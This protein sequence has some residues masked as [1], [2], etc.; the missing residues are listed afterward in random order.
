[1]TKMNKKCL[2]KNKKKIKNKTSIQKK[3]YKTLKITQNKI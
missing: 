2:R 1:M 3:I